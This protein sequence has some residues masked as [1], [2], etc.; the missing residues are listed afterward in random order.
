MPWELDW[1]LGMALTVATVIMH[2]LGL[3]VIHRIFIWLGVA[4]R[5]DVRRNAVRF[6]F[7]LSPVVTATFALHALEVL[8]W[9]AAYLHIGATESW[10]SAV[11][12]SMG[13]FSTYGHAAVYLAPEWQLLGAI[14]ALNGMLIFGLSIAFLAAVIR[15]IWAS[16]PF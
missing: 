14:Q 11:I 2:V 4:L 7:I 6:G 12:Y 10:R 9:A 1:L 15:Q 16:A 8:G 3:G 5:G 13:A